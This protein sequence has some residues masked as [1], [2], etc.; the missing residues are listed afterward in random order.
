M[1]LGFDKW[2]GN[3]TELAAIRTTCSHIQNRSRVLAGLPLQDEVCVCMYVCKYVSMFTSPSISLFRTI[4]T[5][6]KS[7]VSWAEKSPRGSDEVRVMHVQYLR[8]RKMS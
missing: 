1:R 2:W 3:K 6:L 8:P 7:E 5:L 4:V